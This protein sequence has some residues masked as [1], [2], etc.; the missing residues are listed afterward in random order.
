MEFGHR[1]RSIPLGTVLDRL[2]QWRTVAYA[3]S[4]PAETE[5]G[6]ASVQGLNE[7]LTGRIGRLKSILR[8]G[9]DRE[10]SGTSRARSQ[11]S[12]AQNPP[13]T[14]GWLLLAMTSSARKPITTEPRRRARS[15]CPNKRHATRQLCRRV[16]LSSLD[17]TFESDPELDTG[18]LRGDLLA[19]LRRA[20]DLL[21]GPAGTA[22]RAWSAM[23]CGIQDLPP[24]SAT[25]PGPQGGSDA[26]C[27]APGH[28]ARRVS[29]GTIATRQVESGREVGDIKLPVGRSLTWNGQVSSS[30]IMRSSSAAS[31]GRPISWRP[32]RVLPAHACCAP[33]PC[34]RSP[35]GDPAPCAS[36]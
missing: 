23:R 14:T 19:L 29:P 4:V 25:T 3:A 15:W 16:T 9:L 32:P 18:S 36:R 30:T 27:C 34:R 17:T 28:R 5:E 35:S 26:R 11:Y 12:S 31:P 10:V 21:E 22:I 8:R 24:N 13:R 1:A 20:A 6:K 33:R 7:D 2:D